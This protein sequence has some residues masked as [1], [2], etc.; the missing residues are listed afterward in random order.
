MTLRCPSCGG[1]YGGDARFCTQDGSRL[2]DV[3]ATEIDA[4]TASAAGAEHAVVVDFGLAKERKTGAEREKLTATG[5]ILGTS[6]FMSPEQLRGKPLDARSDILALSLMADE[7]L[8]AKLPREGRNAQGM[9]VARLR[10]EPI[11]ARTRR[12]E[13]SQGVDAVLLKAIARAPE[14]RYATAPEFARALRQ[15]TE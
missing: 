11:P 12:P 8:T 3:A 15:A 5:I 13:W 2:V 10:Q 14:D 9:M 7:M 1:V 4:A 6:E